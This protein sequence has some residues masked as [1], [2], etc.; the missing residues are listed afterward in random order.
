MECPP[1]QELDDYAREELANPAARTVE[2]HLSACSECRERLVQL[3]SED[4]ELRAIRAHL[5]KPAERAPTDPAVTGAETVRIVADADSSSEEPSERNPAPPVPAHTVG[6]EGPQPA[7]ADSRYEIIEEVGR[8]GMGAVHKV[9]DRDLRR[10]A[11]MKVLLAKPTQDDASREEHHR[12]RTRFL[13]EAQVTGQLDHPG[14]VPVSDLGLDAEGR[15]YFTMR[16]VRGRNLG[17][18]FELVRKR[19]EGW[20]RTRALEVLIKVCDTLAYAHAKGVL[21]RDLKPANVMVGRFGEVYVMDWGLARV[22]REPDDSDRWQ[23]ESDDLLLTSIH[24]DRRDEVE[25]R[26]DGSLV[27][28][29]G[30]VVGTPVFMPP[31]QAR[32]ELDR[33]GPAADVYAVGA[34]LYTLLADRMPY[35]TPGKRPS[36]RGVLSAL[37]DGP[38]APLRQIAPAMPPE[39]VAI[40]EKAMERRVED[41]YGSAAELGEDLR[42]FLEHR[43]VRAYRTGAVAELRSWFA[44]NRPFAVSAALAVIALVV[45]SVAVAVIQ[46]RAEE[47]SNRA[48][49][50]ARLQEYFARVS[51]AE[52]TYRLNDV[53]LALHKLH[54]SPEELRHWEW[55]YLN[56]GFKGTYGTPYPLPAEVQSLDVQDDKVLIA[57]EDQPPRLFSA[58]TRQHSPV[59]GLE[60]QADLARF[61]PDGK[62]ILGIAKD[63]GAASLFLWKASSSE[64]VETLNGE[65]PEPTCLAWSPG[66]ERFA[67]GH[68]SGEVS[69]WRLGSSDPDE[70]LDLH[71]DLVRDLQFSPDGRLLVTAGHDGAIRVVLTTTGERLP[72]PEES[73]ESAY[74]LTFHPEGGHLAVARGNGSLHVFETEGWN[75]VVQG[76][77]PGGVTKLR[78]VAYS[79]DGSFLVTAG[80]D[81]SI[82]VWDPPGAAPSN[83]LKGHADG[84][85]AVAFTPLGDRL[86]SG[87]RDGTI[88]MWDVPRPGAP[89]DLARTAR[90][91]LDF[92]PKDG[93]L[94]TTT[95]GWSTT[96]DRVGGGEGRIC[97]WDV[98]TLLPARVLHAPRE[99][100]EE[101]LRHWMN[102]VKFARYSPT[103]DSILVAPRWNAAYVLDAETGEETLRLGGLD[104][105]LAA[106]AYSAD[107]RLI[108]GSVLG[109]P[110]VV[111]DGSTGEELV[112]LGGRS[113]S[114]DTLCFSP[115]DGDPLLAGSHY[116]DESISLWNATTGEELGGVPE[117]AHDAPAFSA[118]GRWLAA[119]TP[120]NDVI[121]WDVATGQILYRLRGHQEEIKDLAFSRDGT[122]LFSASGDKFVRVWH[123]ETETQ[124]LQLKHDIPVLE[125]ALSPDGTVLATATNTRVRVW[126]AA[127]RTSS[128]QDAFERAQKANERVDAAARRCRS[129]LADELE[130]EL[131]RDPRLK[132]PARELAVS[133]ARLRGAHTRMRLAYESLS[134]VVTPEADP[135][136][137]EHA[138]VQAESI[139][140]LSAEDA[141][142]RG[143]QAGALYRLHRPEE[144][145]DLLGDTNGGEPHPTEELFRALCLNA[146]G[147][148]GEASEAFGRAESALETVS[149]WERAFLGDTIAEADEVLGST[150]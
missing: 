140:R 74:A 110:T 22:R 4:R 42:A 19:E 47:V 82:H 52:A 34:M 24:T 94:L 20:S 25:E 57:L 32:G 131:R 73:E 86:V 108:A 105:F 58:L 145:L 121:V 66:G 28:R 56:E 143:V 88:R 67:V 43:V 120:E 59:G 90:H 44:R 2:A 148:P 144:A 146:L 71:V 69:L 45:G 39:V 27:T 46:N 93:F 109:V 12:L 126:R 113:E 68:R 79:P 123:I 111:W 18:I 65:L 102:A 62:M 81:K 99:P 134:A 80:E 115:V 3:Q 9:W 104:S 150:P 78:S 30:S 1:L 49:A 89:P 84:I 8:G 5:G 50:E 95:G 15:P 29:D 116:G 136:V 147:R 133:F 72:G 14:V 137:Y 54:D 38:P 125:L 112:R 60:I 101:E 130:E 91:S 41:R 6:S 64:S 98:D 124:L 35:V 77:V 127:E 40:C 128:I 106:A 117:E 129:A 11:A 100:M 114:L 21:H 85:Q 48:A 37:I 13:E 96:P 36:P 149:N 141:A 92:H 55:H 135:A 7:Q 138:R 119:G 63:S 51:A 16:L 132:D 103:G 83:T 97:A 118:D 107:G 122:R 17:A 87:S 75:T 139:A 10:H 53:E 26:P 70:L 31:E 76:S 23:Q 142:A 33:L 61:S